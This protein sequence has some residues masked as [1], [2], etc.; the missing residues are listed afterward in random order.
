MVGQ[1]DAFSDFD[2]VAA[3]GLNGGKTGFVGGVVTCKNW[4]AS[5]KRR[6][7]HVNINR[8]PFADAR[9]LDL[10][11]AFALHEFDIGRAFDCFGQCFEAQRLKLGRM[12]VM[13]RYR[14]GFKFNP[15]ARMQGGQTERDFRNMLQVG[16]GKMHH[17]AIMKTLVSAVFGS[18]RQLLRAQKSINI[19]QPAACH[20]RQCATQLIKQRLKKSVH[21]GRYMGKFRL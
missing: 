21:A 8:R 10:Q 14:R 11:H 18:G 15:Q 4:Y 20:Y 1:T 5:R 9:Q 13:Q 16:L 12:A 2:A 17:T 19:D 6:V 3:H 7:A